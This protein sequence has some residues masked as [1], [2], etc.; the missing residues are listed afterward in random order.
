MR[1][2]LDSKDLI[3][4]IEHG[5]PID[6]AAFDAYLRSHNAT[7]VLT[8]T[9]IREFVAPISENRDFPSIRPYLRQIEKLPVCYLR[10]A[11]IG[12][13]EIIAAK[14]A[15][16]KGG[17]PKRI[18]PYVRRWDHTISYPGPSPVEDFVNLRL[19]EI[20]YFL[21]KDNPKHF[22]PFRKGGVL[23]RNLFAADRQ[24]PRHKRKSLA[25]NFVESVKRWG[26]RWN[27]DYERIDVDTFGHWIYDN[28]T[29]CPG[30]RL[31]YDLFHTM[32]SNVGDI[33]KDSDIPDFSH[34]DAIPYVDQATLDRR[35]MHY[36]R[37]I[38]KRLQKAQPQISYHRY[39]HA[40]LADLLRSVP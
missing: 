9:N 31:G 23:L 21:Y 10:E 17:E 4:V 11:P 38:V 22:E 1:I 30:L 33:P 29:R 27:I 32:L 24:L 20:I 37:T 36:F 6:Y 7:L 15:F 18:N 3:N 40:S 16:V 5:K 39:T 12:A 8:F 26:G 2:L 34:F 25:D 19:D 13:E 28:P 35:M 14:E